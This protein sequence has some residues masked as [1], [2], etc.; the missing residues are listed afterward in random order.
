MIGERWRVVAIDNPERCGASRS[1][2]R[3][4]EPELGPVDD[5]RP[6]VRLSR[7]EGAEVLLKGAVSHL[8]LAV[9]LRVKCC[10]VMPLS[11]MSSA[12]K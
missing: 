2:K 9:G 10:G 12:Q 8:G 11:F 4:V 5:T 7:A 1:L 3:G 6:A